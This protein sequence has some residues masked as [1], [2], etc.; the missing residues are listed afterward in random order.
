MSGLCKDLSEDD[1]MKAWLAL[2]AGVPIADCGFK[3]GRYYFTT[4]PCAIVTINGQI[5]IVSMGSGGTDDKQK[6]PGT[7]RVLL[8]KE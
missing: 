7:I 5:S 1:D 8:P 3:D 4:V 6:D 2:A